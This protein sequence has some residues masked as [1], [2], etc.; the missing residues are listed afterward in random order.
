MGVAYEADDLKLGRYVALNFIPEDLASDLQ[1][2]ERF[3][4]ERFCREPRAASNQI[5][6]LSASRHRNVRSLA[7]HM[8]ALTRSMMMR[9]SHSAALTIGRIARPSGPSVSISSP[10]RVA[11]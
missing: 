6:A 4:L 2:L 3:C 5:T 8:P 1:A 9:L 10:E 11:G 7:R